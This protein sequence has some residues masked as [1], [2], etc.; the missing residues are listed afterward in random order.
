M[1]AP[2]AASTATDSAL[3]DIA[4]RY[5][6]PPG[7]VTVFHQQLV[8]RTAGC[9]V[10]VL[11]HATI[12]E[13]VI[14]RDAIVLE[15]GAPVVWFTFPGAWHDIGRF[16]TCRGDFTGFYA[17]ILTPVRFV[18]PKEW[19]TTDLFLDVWLDARGTSL[20][21]EDELEA[22]VRNG[23]VSAGD[24]IRARAEAAALLDGAAAGTWPPAICRRWTLER[25]TSARRDGTDG[26]P[27]GAVV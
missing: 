5:T 13:P 14:V 15:R 19:E 24:A 8:H 4:I 26:T 21:D 6:R 18:S 11:E 9:I 27:G 12:E 3:T 17:N 1:P 25:A 20:L 16:H 2:A 10:T 23:A 22:A 7:R